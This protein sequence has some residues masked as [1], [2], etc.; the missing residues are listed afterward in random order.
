MK[1]QIELILTPE[2][3]ATDALLKQS[4]ARHLQVSESQITGIELLKKSIDARSRIVKF[5]FVANV[6]IDE[7]FTPETFHYELKNVRDA[8]PVHIIGFGPAGIFAALKLIQLGLKPIIYERGKDVKSRRRDLAEINKAL[9]INPESNYCFGEGGAGTYSDGKLYT[10]SNKRGNLQ[11]I[12]QLFVMH[13]ADARILYEAHPHIGTN[14]LPQIVTKMRESIEACGGEVHFNCKLT[15]IETQFDSVQSITINDNLKIVATQVILAT[16]H[17]ARDIFELLRRKNIFIES[18]PLAIGVRVEHPQHII[19]SSQYKCEVR[20]DYLPPASYSLVTQVKETGVFSFCMCPGGII[21]PA[22]TA[23]GEVVVN[24]W[25]PSKR[26]GRFANSGMVVSIGEKD[27]AK[28][29]KEGPLASLQYQ[30]KIEQDCY[31]A[32]N[33]SIKAPAQRIND[34]IQGKR[35]T[36][37][38]DCSYLP[39]LTSADLQ[40]ILPEEISS[41]L[42]IAL[43]EFSNKIRG[44]NTADAIMVATE[45]RTS[46]PVR[47]TRDAETL[48]HV[49]I[50]GLYPCAEGAGY[51]GGIVSAAIDG[52]RVALSIAQL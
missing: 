31:V 51:A 26:D 21:A 34:F 33:N 47:I 2:Q 14:K 29:A 44:Y 7:P 6:F 38:P 19:D 25:S 36:S 32:G 12:L 45:S 1:S 11:E 52:Q 28:Y 49:Q 9:I 30:R 42:R 3:C 13:G 20:P 15:D 16:G 8:K 35:S 18:K 41:R 27:Y 5:R 22:A 10:R 37:L 40:Q 48:Q 23:G 46:S 17:S 24:G 50:K 43:K 39:G 4:Y